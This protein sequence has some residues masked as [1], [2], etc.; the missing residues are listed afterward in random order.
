MRGTLAPII[1]GL[2]LAAV[3]GCG[4]KGALYLPDEAAEEV[5]EEAPVVV[6]CTASADCEDSV[7]VSRQLQLA[8]F[9]NIV[10]YK[11]GFPEWEAKLRTSERKS[12]LITKGETPGE[13]NS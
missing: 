1:L 3:S 13:T 10:I 8:G 4:Q 6:Y 11:G 12:A 9:Q 2:T 5:P 7:L